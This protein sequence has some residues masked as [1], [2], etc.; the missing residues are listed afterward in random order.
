AARAGDP[1]SA[2]GGV[3]ALTREVDDATAHGLAS[4]FLEVVVAPSFGPAAPEILGGEPQPRPRGAPA[5]KPTLR[6]VE[7]PSIV[8]PAPPPDPLGSIRTAGG[9]VLVTAP[10]TAA[11]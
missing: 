3:V 8:R 7:D 10:D 11:D 1:V 4:I 2:F 5:A 6:L 9:A